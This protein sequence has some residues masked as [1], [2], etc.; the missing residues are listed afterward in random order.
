MTS[1]RSV[2]HS[3]A[4]APCPT[5]GRLSSGS[6]SDAIRAPRPS[7]F[8]PA[9]AR[10][11]ASYAPLVELA[12]PRVDVSAQRQDRQQRIALAQL[13]LAAQARRS[14]ARAARQPGEIEIVIGHER[15]ARIL[16]LGDRREREAVGHVHRH[17]L[18]RM[19]GEVGAAV[20]HR[21]LELLDEEA[22]AADVGERPVQHAIALGRHAEQLDRR[23]PDRARRGAR[24]RARPATSRARTR[25]WRW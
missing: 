22:L 4:S 16:A 10:M 19:H 20:R 14:D 1:G 5:A 18:Q 3:S 17:V 2:R 11:I 6:S 7:R 24:G 21:Q 25:A 8:R 9:A 12:Q 23:C 13:R 15:V